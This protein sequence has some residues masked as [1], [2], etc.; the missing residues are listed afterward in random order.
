MTGVLP[1]APPFA[2]PVCR[3]PLAREGGVFRCASRHAYDIAR[4]GYV[5]LLRRPP[6]TLYE[7]KALF[8]ARRAVYAAGFFDPVAEAVRAA[9]P[10]GL[11]L[12][13]GCGEGSMLAR[14]A[15]A[16]QRGIGLDI[17]QPAV[18]MAAGA[19]KHHAWCVGDVCA[20]PLLDASV[21]AVLNM[22]TPANHAEFARVL[23]PAGLLLKVVPGAMHLLEIRRASGKPE[24][25][26]EL[27]ATHRLMARHFSMV[28]AQAIRYAVACDES[29]AAQVFAMTP[30]TV[31]TQRPASLPAS[32]TV[33]VTLLVG[34]RGA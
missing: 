2:C 5:N 15:A 16:G 29:L 21:D 6:D 27:E 30:L 14:V 10:E 32:V 31:H 22:L 12:D 1:P 20:I 4:Q 13:A 34:R 26:G 11:V 17:A 3:R 24:G 9:L 18:Q 7:D 33:D 8:A 28:S 23:R 19:Y 25:H